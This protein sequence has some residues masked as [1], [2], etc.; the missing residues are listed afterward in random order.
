ML[1]PR[2]P[3]SQATWR[4]ELYPTEWTFSSLHVGELSRPC[5]L[6]SNWW[7]CS[8]IHGCPCVFSGCFKLFYKYLET[9][10]HLTF[11]LHQFLNAGITTVELFASITNIPPTLFSAA[12]NSRSVVSSNKP[13]ALLRWNFRKQ[14]SVM[15]CFI[16]VLE[17]NVF[18]FWFFLFVCKV[19]SQKTS[20]VCA[21][22]MF[23]WFSKSKSELIPT[24]SRWSKCI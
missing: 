14:D 6:I 19:W 7:C 21:R 20:L 15:L 4:A 23:T 12:F 3:A 16:L 8:L 10:F 17:Y 11:S 1:Q 2:V 24:L 22:V 5:L 18:L 9:V 13:S